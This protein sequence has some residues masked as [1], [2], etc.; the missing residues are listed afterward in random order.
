VIN[1]TLVQ[2]LKK[3]RGRI[4]AAVLARTGDFSL[5]E[6]AVQEA[7]ASALIHWARSGPPE[8]PVAW[9][10][11]VAFRKAM[12]RLRYARRN[13]AAMVALGVLARDEAAPDPE[14]IADERLRLIFT[15]CHPAL[16]PKTQVCLTLRSV[17]GLSTGEIARAFLDQEATMAQRLSRAKAKISAAA[18]PFAVPEAEMWPERLQVVLSVVYLIFNAGYTAG[19]SEP[20]DLCGEAIFLARLIDDLRP[21]QSE[22]EGCL[23]L[24]LLTHARQLA[25]SKDGVTVPITS[26]DRNLWDQGLWAEGLDLIDR[27]VARANPGPYQIKAAIAACHDTTP[28]DWA[29]IAALYEALILYEPTPVVRLNHAVALA[30]TGAL[31]QALA[32]L[33]TLAPALAQYQPYHAACA[34]YLARAESYEAAHGAFARAIALAASSADAAYLINRRAGLPVWQANP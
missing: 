4:L 21:G 7:A 27:A 10:I 2:V 14:D 5:A 16:E 23:A 11:R 28:P 6:E 33:E 15:C 30:E 1:A 18:I 25:R 8:R 34:E 13:E 9:L 3:D 20:R 26:Q 31:V 22:V 12:D 17:C 32:L 19:P 29:Q 24:M